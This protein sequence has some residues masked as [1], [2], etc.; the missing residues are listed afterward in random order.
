M[1]WDVV[2]RSDGLLRLAWRIQAACYSVS[3]VEDQSICMK[4]TYLFALESAAIRIRST[5]RLSWNGRCN[6]YSRVCCIGGGGIV[7]PRLLIIAVGV[8]DLGRGVRRI[9]ILLMRR[10][11][12]RGLLVRGVLTWGRRHMGSGRRGGSGLLLLLLPLLLLQRRRPDSLPF[13]LFGAKEGLQGRPQSLVRFAERAVERGVVA[14]G[15]VFR[16]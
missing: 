9:P 13:L 16:E 3:I 5:I 6:L 14:D 1:P 7:K 12:V 10:G 8:C 15:A 2:D 4:T 11:S